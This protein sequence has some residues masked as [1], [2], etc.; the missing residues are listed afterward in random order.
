MVTQSLP[1]AAQRRAGPRFAWQLSFTRF[2]RMTIQMK[3]RLSILLLLAAGAFS[4]HALADPATVRL[5]LIAED[6]S[7]AAVCDLMTVELSRRPGIQLLERR[8]IEKVYREQ[9]LSTVQRDLLRL[10]NVL[11]A[12]GVLLLQPSVEGTNHFLTARL[13]AVKPGVIIATTRTGFSATDATPSARWMAKLFEPLLPKLRVSAK[14]AVPISIVNLRSAIQT[15]EAPEVEQQ[16]MAL[17]TERLAREPELFVLERRRMDLLSDEKE[18][19]GMDE[20]AFWNGSFLLDAVVDR[21]GYSKDTIT[22]QAELAAPRGGPRSTFKVSGARTNLSAVVDRLGVQVRDHLKLKESGAPWEPAAEAARYFEEAQWAFRWK[23][24]NEAQEAVE[25]S[26][27]LGRQ[28]KESAELRLRIHLAR[29]TPAQINW[30]SVRPSVPEYAPDVSLLPRSIHTI[31]LY[32]QSFHMFVEND[33][34]PNTN[35]YSLSIDVL[36]STAELLRRFYYHPESRLTHED[37]LA[38]L[39]QS[40]REL[41]GILE[42]HPTYKNLCLPNRYI[43]WIQGKDLWMNSHGGVAQVEAG[44]GCLWQETPEQ[45]LETYRRLASFVPLYALRG[46]FAG[47]F[48]IGWKAGDEQ[49]A[50]ALWR[51]FLNELCASTNGATRVEGLY[52]A[53]LDVSHDP[54]NARAAREK[55]YAAA[56]ENAPA[57]D[58]GGEADNLRKDIWDSQLPDATRRDWQTAQDFK[59]SFDAAIEAGR[60]RKK[61]QAQTAFLKSNSPFR[62]IEFSKMFFASRY[63]VD[64][65]RE[66]LPLLNNYKM[67]LFERRNEN[68]PPFDAQWTIVSNDI[69]RI[70]CRMQD[71]ISSATSSNAAPSSVA[72]TPPPKSNPTASPFGKPL[73]VGR[74]WNIPYGQLL[75]DNDRYGTTTILQTRFA[76]DRLWLLMQM[77]LRDRHKTIIFSVNL[78][79]YECESIE[80]PAGTSAVGWTSGARWAAGATNWT[81]DASGT[82]EVLNEALYVCSPAG[83][84]R[85]TFKSRLWDKIEVP[86]EG[87]NIQLSQVD[88]RLFVITADSIMEIVDNE[89]EV[90]ILA[91]GRRRPALN[92]LDSLEKFTFNGG[93]PAVLFSGPAHALCAA[94]RGRIYTCD[95]TNNQWSQSLVLPLSPNT[96]STPAFISSPY[97]QVFRQA[98]GQGEIRWWLLSS[99]SS[100]PEL[101]LRRA[102]QFRDEEKLPPARWAFPA[103]ITNPDTA[104]AWEKDGLR[105]FTGNFS[106]EENPAGFFEFLE[107]DGCQAFL[108][109]CNLNSTTPNANPLRFDLDDELLPSSMLKLTRNVR[110]SR[111]STQ[112]MVN[113]YIPGKIILQSAPQGLALT[114]A[115]IPGFWLIPG[116]ESHPFPNQSKKY[117][118]LEP[119]ARLVGAVQANDLVTAREALLHGADADARNDHGRTALMMAALAGNLKMTHLLLEK[120]ANANALSEPFKATPVLW[121]AVTGNNPEIVQAVLDHGADLNFHRDGHGLTA[122]VSAVMR[123]KKEAAEVLISRGADV[124]DLF[125]INRRDGGK[126][127]FTPLMA[128]SQADRPEMVDLLLTHG[129]RIEM[130]NSMNRTVLQEAAMSRGAAAL[131]FLIEKGADI[132]VTTPD[133]WTPLIAAAYYGRT[134]NVKILLAAGADPFATARDDNGEKIDAAQAAE[135]N[136]FTETASLIR[137]AQ[138]NASATQLVKAPSNAP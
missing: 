60:G 16:L 44:P 21:D 78:D 36:Q 119:G 51:E 95:Q 100:A 30:A 63:S 72:A 26:W 3:K 17:T 54:E 123:G 112:G 2:H 7:T 70:E 38:L 122:L 91:S 86:L 19:K 109:E 29:S 82:F 113:V 98:T 37:N 22:L 32:R 114:A 125:E 120:G 130:R 89:K 96:P 8:E 77:D 15:A 76:N 59:K 52:L 43:F 115:N 13:I 50:P 111:V 48:L 24:F 129:A 66:L 81:T 65:A 49:R 11:G 110:Y 93:D 39:R 75:H 71:A 126:M 94:I 136:R 42:T 83:I 41:A 106:M 6:P 124:N 101:L 55:L 56:I 25:S 107:H 118:T 4:G 137:T 88:G 68:P 64:E 127:T 134:E 121:F 87:H 14:E 27:A 138:K 84:N 117:L 74:Y 132:H 103:G 97:G 28:D 102:G 92:V 69:A 20:S 31:Q 9:A 12:D 34:I 45:C 131:K 33:P 85:Y 62:Q 90:R 99:N 35:W 80:L 67:N 18:L 53:Y 58:V 47:R 105:I 128:A 108:V 116:N 10:G 46:S 1:G 104:F 5:A 135:D 23:L 57:F 73:R 133:G 61:L 40:A 79:D